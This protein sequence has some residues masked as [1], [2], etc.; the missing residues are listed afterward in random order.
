MEDSQSVVS[1]A[2]SAADY[3][4]TG[5][6]PAEYP[7]TGSVALSGGE[8]LVYSVPTAATDYAL[9]D[10]TNP[11]DRNMYSQDPSSVAQNATYGMVYESKLDGGA[12]V[13]SENAIGHETVAGI[14]THTSGHDSIHG[15]AGEVASYQP[16]GVIENG[17]LSNDVGGT[18]VQQSYEDGIKI[19][20]SISTCEVLRD[21]SF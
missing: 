21:W 13:A 11:D 10:G 14:S 6:V 5:H 4:S 17:D 12:A 2:S 7:M 20:Y 15:G 16:T 9:S 8:D 3:S 19:F 1:Q 18:V